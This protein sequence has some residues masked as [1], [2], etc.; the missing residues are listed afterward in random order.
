MPSG[1]R[2]VLRR[3]RDSAETRKPARPIP[4][5]SAS[6]EPRPDGLY[7]TWFG[8]ASCLVELDGARIL[9]DPVWSERVSPSQ[10]VGPKRL[11]ANPVELEDLPRIDA[12]VISHKD[13]DHS[14][15]AACCQNVIGS[16]LTGVSAI[17]ASEVL[18]P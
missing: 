9:L 13:A 4:V 2:D 6:H 15:G 11:H 10:Q 1:Q 8:H 12:V 17:A 16:A 7:I 14:G 3:F 18:M 5:V